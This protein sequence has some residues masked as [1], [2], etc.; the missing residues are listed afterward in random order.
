MRN[1]AQDF[2][3]LSTTVHNKPLIYLDSAA[4]AQKPQVVIDV[5]NELHTTCNANIHRGIHHLAERTTERYEQA[6]E[7]VRTLINADSTSEIIFTSGA[8]ASINLVAYSYGEKFINEGDNIIVSEMEHHSN[9]VP[10]QMVAQRK[11]AQIRVLPFADNGELIIEQL[12]A[13]IDDRTRMV[14]V[15]QASN[16]LGTM[17][18]LRQIVQIA[19]SHGV[20]VLVDGCQG[21]VHTTTDVQ[22]LDV[23]FYCFSG[24]KL[25]APT[26][27]G[28]LYGKEKWLEQMPPFM[29]GGDMIATVTFQKTTYA[30]LPLK[31]E[32]GTSN[33]IGAI[34]LGTAI[35]YVNDLSGSVDMHKLTQDI[36]SYFASKLCTDIEG[37]TVYGNCLAKS[38]VTAFTIEDTHPMDVAMII[39]KLGVAIRSGTHCAEPIMQHYSLSSMCRASFGIYNTIQDADVAVAAIKRAVTMLRG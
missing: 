12:E 37:V 10:W 19:H 11:G 22:A 30:E 5:V 14:A 34:A 23:D 24:H 38:P 7:K 6:R 17:P 31:F 21:I 2:P 28:V 32:A 25:Y 36:N 13:M 9:I 35:D 33:F 1:I 27:I 20:C 3:I 26:G 4:T 8:T 39:D 15:T 16:V 29:G 18:N